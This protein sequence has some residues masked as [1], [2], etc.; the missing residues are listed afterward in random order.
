[1]GHDSFIWD[2]NH[3]YGTW[4]IYWVRFE[5]YSCVCDRTHA[6]GTWLIFIWDMTP[7]YGIVISHMTHARTV[8]VNIWVMS[9]MKELWHIWISHVPY[10]GVC[11]IWMSH[12]TYA[13]VISNIDESCPICRSHVTYG[14]VTSHMHQSCPISRNHVT[15]RWVT[16]HIHARIMR[17]TFIKQ[18]FRRW[19]ISDMSS[20]LR[21]FISWT[22]DLFHQKSHF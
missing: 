10:A 3:S 6:Y 17:D 11:H 5:A 7:S 18:K 20:T 12:V 21:H 2:M 15:Y 22:W 4:L 19:K 9:H 13:G 1:M 16:S 8:W 14:W